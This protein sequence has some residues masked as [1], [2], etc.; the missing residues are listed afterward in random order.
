PS[1]VR[2][3]PTLVC[4]RQCQ[5]SFCKEKGEKYVPKEHFLDFHRS[6]GICGGLICAR[7][8]KGD[9]ARS[10]EGNLA[11]IRARHVHQLL[12]GMPWQGWQRRRTRG[13]SPES[14]SH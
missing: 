9:Q 13:G 12:C 7:T 4:S 10:R 2:S 3:P 6:G 11:C 1:T 8:A 5:Q 14:P